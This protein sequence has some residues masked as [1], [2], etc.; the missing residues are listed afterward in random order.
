M[1]E[2]L[3]KFPIFSYIRVYGMHNVLEVFF[4]RAGDRTEAPF[5]DHVRILVQNA[6]VTPSIPQINADRDLVLKRLP[7]FLCACVSSLLAPALV[8]T[9]PSHHISRAQRQES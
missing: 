6:I 9:S 7:D 5:F 3:L 1:G 4:H 8:S 2:N